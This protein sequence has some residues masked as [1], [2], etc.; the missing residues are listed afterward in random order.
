MPNGSFLGFLPGQFKPSKIRS[1]NPR[2]LHFHHKLLR[3]SSGRHTYRKE[4][5][6]SL[7]RGHLLLAVNF[8]DSGP[9]GLGGPPARG[10]FTCSRMGAVLRGRGAAGQTDLNAHG[11]HLVDWPR[12]SAPGLGAAAHHTLKC[13]WVQAV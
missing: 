5:Q 12:A 3:P 1:S 4:C 8:T 10:R 9:Q 2:G 7:T 6:A 13:V 11:G